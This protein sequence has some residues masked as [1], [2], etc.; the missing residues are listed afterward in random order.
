MTCTIKISE[1][2]YRSRSE[3]RAGGGDGHLCAR[4]RVAGVWIHGDDDHL[5]GSKF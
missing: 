4:A 3:K 1:S 5:D 2:P